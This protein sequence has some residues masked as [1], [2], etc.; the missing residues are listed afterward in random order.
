MKSF[1]LIMWRQR[2][3]ITGQQD[4]E[5]ADK[6]W[7]VEPRDPF[8]EKSRKP[9]ESVVATMECIGNDE[10]RNDKENLNAEPPV[11]STRLQNP[12]G[13]DRVGVSQMKP[14]HRQRRQPAQQ[15]DR[16]NSFLGR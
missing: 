10:S 16:F 13:G 6:I 8:N 15:V 2:D 11:L 9:L 7:R 12:P 3:Q 1:S 14:A 4:Q 5:N